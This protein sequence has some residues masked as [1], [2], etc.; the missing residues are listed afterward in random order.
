MLT[1][2]E[3]RFH[4]QFLEYYLTHNCIFLKLHKQNTQIDK[5]KEENEDHESYVHE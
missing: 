3:L 2:K 5:W 1:Q 4:T